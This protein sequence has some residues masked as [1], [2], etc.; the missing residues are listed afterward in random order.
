MSPRRPRRGLISVLRQEQ[1]GKHSTGSH[2]HYKRRCRQ[3][4]VTKYGARGFLVTDLHKIT[5]KL[6]GSYP[7]AL[8]TRGNDRA[9]GSYILLFSRVYRLFIKAKM[10]LCRVYPHT[11]H[12]LL[13][14]IYYFLIPT[15]KRQGYIRNYKTRS[16]F[17]FHAHSR[18]VITT[19][20]PLSCSSGN[21]VGV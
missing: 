1:C 17:L 13:R 4:F 19:V 7:Y 10:K 3:L 14:N 18:W 16:V 8:L 9:H 5:F 12:S 11:L 2:T 15:S 20:L 21:V 6:L